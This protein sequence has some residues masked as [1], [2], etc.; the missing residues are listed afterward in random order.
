MISVLIERS[1]ISKEKSEIALMKATGF[2][3]RSIIAQHALRFAIVAAASSVIATA[4]CVPFTKLCVDPIF[5][6]MG[7]I[8]GVEYNINPVEVCIVYPIIVI[9]ATLLGAFLTSIYMKKIKASD[10]SDIE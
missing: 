1:F 5:G 2:K 3:T 8:N 6:I 9:S 4:L 10:T 7:A